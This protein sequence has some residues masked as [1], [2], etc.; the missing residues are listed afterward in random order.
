MSLME[1]PGRPSKPAL[2]GRILRARSRTVRRKL[3]QRF[4]LRTLEDVLPEDWSVPDSEVARKAE[5]AARALCQDFVIEHSYRTYCFAA[6]LATRDGLKIDREVVFIASILHDLGLSDPHKDDEGS[7]EWVGARLAHNF[8]KNEGLAEERAALV[9]NAIALH[10]SLGIADK[11]TPEIAMVHFGAGTDLF[12]MRIDDVPA[13]DLSRLL[14]A[15]PRDSFKT[16]FSACLMHQAETKPNSHIAGPV[17][18]GI[19]GRIVADLG[20]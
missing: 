8:C 7:F 16:C 3:G 5:K 4:G 20:D 12:G 13:L 18:L 17:A 9:H 11:S 10:S 6:I 19:E 15:H 1:D 2:I 14:E